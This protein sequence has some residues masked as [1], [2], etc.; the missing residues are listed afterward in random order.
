MNDIPEAVAAFI[1][2]YIDSVEQLELL[3]FVQ[4]NAEQGWT[5]R[6]L[7]R[8]LSTNADAVAVRAAEFAS[9]GILE[10][11]RSAEG[12]TF[13][14]HPRPEI[15]TAIQQLAQAYATYPIRIVNLIFSK[16]IDKIKTFS[17]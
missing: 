6:D 15:E 5:A 3:L 8:R 7:G 11:E 17:E 2:R 9:K 16:P 4:R 10:S 1:Q 13:R 12:L 14:Y